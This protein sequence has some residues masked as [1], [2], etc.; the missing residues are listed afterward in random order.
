MGAPDLLQHLRAAGLALTV[1]EDRLIVKPRERLTDPDRE[2]IRAHRD[3]LVRLL[4]PAPPAAA[5]SASTTSPPPPRP[6][7]LTRGEA[8]AAHA[9]G[10]DDGEIARFTNRMAL[11]ARRGFD[12]QDAEDLAARLALRDRNG[13]DLRMCV[14]CSHLDERGRCLAAAIG[15]LRGADRRLEPVPILLQRCE[16]FGLRK[17][18]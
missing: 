17:G 10:W 12:Q 14:E 6:H 18:C 1:E 13:D 3:E 16:A 7:A 15:R 2:A 9:G 5:I 4:R 8:Y 11:F